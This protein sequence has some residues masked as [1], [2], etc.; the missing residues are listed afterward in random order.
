LNKDLR[1]VDEPE[2][3]VAKLLELFMGE[4][5]PVEVRSRL[6]LLLRPLIAVLTRSRTAEPA[7]LD[8]S[9]KVGLLPSP[10][11]PPKSCEMSLSAAAGCED[12]CVELPDFRLGASECAL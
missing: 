11:P 7:E 2:R 5:S 3:E 12:G 4:N 6:L 1:E 10:P 9:P 8:L